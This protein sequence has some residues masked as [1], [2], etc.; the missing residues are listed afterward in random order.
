[1]NQLHLSYFSLYLT[2]FR[3]GLTTFGGGFAMSAVLRH[4]I[5]LK[6]G[7]IGER[8]FLNSLSTASA[9]PGAVS[10]NLAFLIGHRFRGLRGGIA[11]AVGQFSPS[12]LCI[13]LVVRFAL[14][15]FESP[16]V[17][18]FLKGAAIA[19]AGQIAFA[20]FIFARRLRPHWH[21]ALVCVIGL[22]V[23]A[24]G[25][26]PVWAVFTTAVLGSILMRERMIRREK[27]VVDEQGLLDTIESISADQLVTEGFEAELKAII[28]EH[29]SSIPNR[30]DTL[31][32]QCPVLDLG[33]TM[34]LEQFMR[35]V[36]DRLAQRVGMPAKELVTALHRREIKSSTVLNGW[37]AVPHIVVGGEK[38]FEILIARS[39]EGIRFSDE[40]PQVRAIFVLLGSVD[41]RTFY[42]NTLA[43][44]AGIAGND[45]FRGQW[46]S[47]KDEGQIRDAL[48]LTRHG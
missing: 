47:A 35:L 26:H 40:A 1:M 48:L 17:Q 39:R 18:A 5:V 9:V 7:W 10:V 31:I 20:A 36:A 32:R 37:L 4:E 45:Q 16:S 34:N 19:V 2:F 44:I 12:V 21:N 8:E 11:A 33:K 38:S 46:M 24:A 27:T 42:L 14:P 3:I 28:G 41:E 15:Y 29:S 22:A 6:R 43:F 25:L 23:V 13:L 30:L